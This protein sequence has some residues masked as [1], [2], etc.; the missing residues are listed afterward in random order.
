[1]IRYEAR[2]TIAGSMVGCTRLIFRVRASLNCLTK[3]L[4][5]AFPEC[6]AGL[7]QIKVLLHGTIMLPF[8]PGRGS[9]LNEG[10]FT[11][12]LKR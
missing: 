5:F 11:S 4:S 12:K 1:M 3:Q 9:I 6:D 10:C 2:S 8:F 7:L